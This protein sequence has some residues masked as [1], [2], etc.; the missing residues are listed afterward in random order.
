MNSS[1]FWLM[2]WQWQTQI[3]NIEKNNA[4][5]E[6]GKKIDWRRHILWHINTHNSTWMSIQVEEGR[7]WSWKKP[8][9]KKLS[10]IK[11]S[12]NRLFQCGIFW[13]NYFHISE[14][15]SREWYSNNN[16]KWHGEWWRWPRRREPTP[17]I[18]ILY[19]KQ[20]GHTHIK[21]KSIAKIHLGHK[22]EIENGTF[23]VCVCVCMW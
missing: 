15:C 8:K 16:T 22:I 1:E 7:I 10:E 2:D 13:L 19:G 5:K 18:F 9:K 21:K 23:C 14:W 20:L 6:L 4:A 12:H 17:N 3:E 11:K